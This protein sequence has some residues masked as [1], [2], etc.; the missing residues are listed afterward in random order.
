MAGDF[1]RENAAAA[2][3]VGRVLGIHED[4]IRSAIADFP[5]VPGRME[6]IQ[7]EPFSV[8]VDYA[9]TPDSLEMVYRTLKTD[10]S[11]LICVLGSAGGGRGKWKRPKFGEIASKYCKEIILTDEDPFDEDPT[12]IL[13]EIKSGILNNKIQMSNVYEI[14]DRKEA[15][16]KAVS[17][18]SS[19]DT[20]IITGKGSEPYIRVRNG[21]RIPW[22]D[23]NAVLEIL[24]EK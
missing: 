13:K 14:L 10:R 24:A 2:V 20:V 18:A 11:G 17:L 9:H 22:L 7:K 23:R 15:I 8:I 6:Y 19:G 16:R 3:A 5:G 1:N 21:K 12:Q 4:I